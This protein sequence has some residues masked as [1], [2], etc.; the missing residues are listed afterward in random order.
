MSDDMEKCPHTT[1][2]PITGNAKQCMACGKI[3]GTVPNKLVETVPSCSTLQHGWVQQLD[4]VTVKCYK[5]GE[6]F[7]RY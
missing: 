6:E 3:E 5:C 7:K 2:K 4:G 1:M